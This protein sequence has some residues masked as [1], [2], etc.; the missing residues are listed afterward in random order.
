M[1]NL[2][3]HHDLALSAGIAAPLA[4]HPTLSG[5]R[6]GGRGGPAEVPS[7]VT[8]EQPSLLG[9]SLTFVCKT[10]VMYF[11]VASARLVVC[12]QHVNGL[13]FVM[14]LYALLFGVF[15][16]CKMNSKLNDL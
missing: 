9:R 10:A 8:R 5:P 4:G 6:W 14:L 13:Y 3:G 1:G 16:R 15:Q 7:T 12:L 11:I 2:H